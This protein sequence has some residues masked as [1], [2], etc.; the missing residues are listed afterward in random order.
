VSPEILSALGEAMARG[1]TVALVTIVEARGSTPQRVGARMLV[2]A[3]G[4]IVGTIGGGCYESD[5]FGKAREIIR[6]RTPQ[7]VRY[8]LTDD[9]AAE[10]GLICGGQMQVF[11]E[12]VDPAPALYILGAGHVG[13][14][15]GRLAPALGFRV[16]VVDDREKFAN[17]ERFPDAE[18]VIVDD[19]PGWI[20]QAVLP[21]SALVVVLTRGHRQDYD[22]VRALA[23]RRL[24][25]VG[26]I[27]S[28]AKVAKLVERGLAEGL[29]VDWLR[30]VH[31]PVGLDIGAVT[32]EEIAVSILAE[33]VAVRRGRIADPAVQGLSMKWT[34]PLLR[35][36]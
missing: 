9:F 4:R 18:A 23:G 14:Q 29:P 34:A 32:P 2:H 36:T 22:A 3:D 35:E 24:R 19:I 31:A 8:E 17:R 25:Y 6:S 11:I 28:R 30:S 1:E 16:Y 26:L 33:L 20:D 13:L 27:G 12:P 15:L 7:L 10:T 21:E 5:A